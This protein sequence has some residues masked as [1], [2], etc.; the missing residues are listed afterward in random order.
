MLVKPTSWCL[1]AAREAESEKSAREAVGTLTSPVNTHRYTDSAVC[2]IYLQ[3][4]GSLWISCDDEGV[5]VYYVRREALK[6]NL[7]LEIHFDWIS[8][9][10]TLQLHCQIG[11]TPVHAKKHFFFFFPFPPLK[12]RSIPCTLLKSRAILNLKLGQKVLSQL[13]TQKSTSVSLNGESNDW[14]KRRSFNCVEEKVVLYSFSSVF[15][16]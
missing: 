16:T 13:S 4:M 7:W 10:W 6:T 14:M 1:E 5:S 8:R 3:K 12:Q 11:K 15:Y 2:V 9:P